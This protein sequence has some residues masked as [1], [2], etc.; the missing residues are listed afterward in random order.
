MCMGFAE[1]LEQI[2]N[3][4][5]F[6]YAAKN[7]RMSFLTEIAKFKK[8]DRLIRFRATVTPDEL[9]AKLNV[10][11]ATF[12]RIIARYKEEFEAPVYFD[13]S[14]NS[15]CYKYKGKLIIKWVEDEDADNSDSD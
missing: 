12:F 10:S 7:T 13:R 15:Y 6:F 8:I 5:N 4:R 1:P 14:I 9:A 3:P 11:R 2:I